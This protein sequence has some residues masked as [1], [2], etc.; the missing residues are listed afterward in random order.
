[1]VRR[2]TAV[3]IKELEKNPNTLK[4]KEGHRVFFIAKEM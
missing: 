3:E 2:C 1:M 4:E